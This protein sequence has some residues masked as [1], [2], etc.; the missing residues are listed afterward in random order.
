MAEGEAPTRNDSMASQPSQTTTLLPF[1]STKE[2]LLPLNEA[3]KRL[4]ISLRT[5]E[6]WIYHKRIAS[7]KLFGCRRIRESTVDAI[8]EANTTPALEAS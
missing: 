4:G 7:V 1:P 3:A 2:R 5:L 8:I 6:D